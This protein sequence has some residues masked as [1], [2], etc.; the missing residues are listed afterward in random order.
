MAN[1]S[2]ACHESRLAAILRAAAKAPGNRARFQSAGLIA[3]SLNPN[4]IELVPDWMQK[5]DALEPLSKATVRRNPGA[6]LAGVS[7]IVYR[8]STSGSQDRAYIYFADQLWNQQR[9]WSR[10]HFLSWW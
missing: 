2:I 8:G 1:R 10:D 9:Q 4:T 6:F 7:D 5:F 3:P